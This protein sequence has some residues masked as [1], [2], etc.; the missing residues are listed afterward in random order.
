MENKIP[1]IGTN[2]FNDLASAYF[3]GKPKQETLEE[4]FLDIIKNVLQFSNDAQ[5]IRFMEKYFEAKQKISYSEE[6]VYHI[7]CE[8]TAYMF[9]EEKGITLTEWFEK[10]KKK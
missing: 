8:H 3:G 6:E 7:L 9:K 5:A 4:Y 10:F 1:Q 2:E